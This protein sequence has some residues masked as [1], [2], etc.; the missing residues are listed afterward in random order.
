MPNV[1]I[2]DD[3]HGPIDQYVKALRKAGY[4]VE[5]LDTLSAAFRHIRD[6]SSAPDIY[7]LDMMMSLGEDTSDW[8]A[9]FSEQ[10]A[11]FGMTAG[12]AIFRRVRAR[13]PSVPVILLT[14]VAEPGILENMP[15]DEHCTVEFKINLLPLAMVNRVKQ[16][17]G[18]KH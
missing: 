17:I 12:L 18:L 9:D 11:G 14:S 10:E 3:D 7:I 13:F 1:V 4:Y 15:F 8:P 2:I 16:R 5:H 6:T